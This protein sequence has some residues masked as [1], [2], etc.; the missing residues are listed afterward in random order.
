MKVVDFNEV[1]GGGS[2][3]ISDLR[4]FISSDGLNKQEEKDKATAHG[5]RVS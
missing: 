5:F 2:S 1:R 3:T 4:D